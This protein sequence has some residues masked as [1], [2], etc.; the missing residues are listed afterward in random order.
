ML[1]WSLDSV[2]KASGRPAATELEGH[3]HHQ[4]HSHFH[5]PKD[6]EKNPGVR[7]VFF[8]HFLCVCVFRVSV[9]VWGGKLEISEGFKSCHLLLGGVEHPKGPWE[10]HEVFFRP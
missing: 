10:C 7:C 4:Q 5:P 9:I 1:A 2:N 3:N 6:M 8:C